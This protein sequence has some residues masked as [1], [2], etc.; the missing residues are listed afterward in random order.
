MNRIF[1]IQFLAT[2]LIMVACVPEPVKTDPEPEPIPLDEPTSDE[3]PDNLF[4]QF[5]KFFRIQG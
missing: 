4:E 2:V 1:I 5:E 3:K